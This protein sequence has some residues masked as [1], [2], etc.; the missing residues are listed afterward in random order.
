MGRPL[1][2]KFFG[3]RNTGSATT[4]ADDGIGGNNVGSVAVTGTFGGKTPGTYTIAAG[5]ISAPQL[6]GGVKPTLL[7]V[8]ATASTA[9]VTVVDSGS[10]YTSAPTISGGTLQ[11]LGGA[12]SGTIVLTATL[13]V[14]TGSVGSATNQE[15]A[16]TMTAFLTGGSAL[17]VDI[18]RQVSGRRYKVTD[19]TRTGTVTLT[20]TLADAAGECSVAVTDSVGGQYFATKITAHKVTVTPAGGSGWLYTTGQAAPWTFAAASG[21]YL[22][23]ANA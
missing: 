16:I 18:I 17:N 10:G 13:A 20:S 8:Y 2:K 21:I 4:T 19:G 11:S 12:G 7:L 6:P 22:Q 23:I 9:T 1:N 15:N 14:D 5:S 3:N